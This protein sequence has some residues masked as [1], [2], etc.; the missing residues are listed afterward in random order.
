M[1]LIKQEKQ[2]IEIVADKVFDCEGRNNYYTVKKRKE[3]TT[4]LVSI[5]IPDDAVTTDPEIGKS[6]FSFYAYPSDTNYVIN[7]DLFAEIESVSKTDSEDIVTV[8]D[9]NIKGD[10]GVRQTS[11]GV[12]A[13]AENSI[14]I[15]FT[16]FDG[17][18]LLG[19]DGLEKKAADIKALLNLPLK[20]YKAKWSQVSTYNPYLSKEFINEFDTLLATTY[21]V[22]FYNSTQF[23]RTSQGVYTLSVSSIDGLPSITA[24][25]IQIINFDNDDTKYITINKSG[26]DLVIQNHL[27]SDNSLVDGFECFII[28]NK[29][30]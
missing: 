21:N 22:P 10:T 19:S 7:G 26:T 13:Q 28:I 1:K 27:V 20:R 5:L 4:S 24:M 8:W 17:D 12:P 25:D 2:L 30:E 11:D 23:V 29:W 9:E 14:L 16:A 18:G 6:S 3:D 15:D